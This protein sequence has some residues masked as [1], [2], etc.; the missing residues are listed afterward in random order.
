MKRILI[1]TLALLMSQMGDAQNN[2]VGIGTNSPDPSAALDIESTSK[3]VLIPRM[4]T[5]NRSNISNPEKGLLVFDNNTVSFWF[6]NGTVWEEIVHEPS[7]PSHWIGN[8]SGI[9][10]PE[11]VG[12]SAGYEPSSSLLIDIINDTEL[13]GARIR[14]DSGQY[15]L[16][17]LNNDRTVAAAGDAGMALDVLGRSLFRNE[18]HMK[19][20][21]IDINN[22]Q[23]LY[24]K[25]ESSFH[26][27]AIFAEFNLSN[28]NAIYG[29]NSNGNGFAGY[30]EGRLNV[31]N[32]A[33]FERD[34][35][36]LLYTSPSPRD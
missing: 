13:N 15:A 4:S 9:H 12:I 17:L 31:T 26:D 25:G 10:F 24:V 29:K 27:N 23:M 33:Q 7:E 2:N 8:S 21:G 34:V 20:S 5:T 6:Y 35:T 14:A 18:V 11:N 16:R 19:S 22:N 36:C 32:D 1:L 28:K 30:F 3:G